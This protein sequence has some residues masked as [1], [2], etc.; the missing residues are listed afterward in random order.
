MIY[1]SLGQLVKQA[2]NVSSLDVSELQT[3]IYFV[4]IGNQGI[5]QAKRFIKK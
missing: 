4:Q 3:G 5:K 1:N 2:Q